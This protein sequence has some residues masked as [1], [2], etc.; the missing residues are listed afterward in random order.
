MPRVYGHTLNLPP[1]VVLIA[2][3]VGGRLLG[4]VGVL[5]AL[6][7]AAVGRVAMDYL[8]ETRAVLPSL[9]V[10]EPAAPDAEGSEA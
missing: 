1:I 9:P 10:D 3:L 7:A 4:V 8:I 5:F 6:P 2:V